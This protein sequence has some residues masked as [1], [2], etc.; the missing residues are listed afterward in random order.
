[1]HLLE[2]SFFNFRNLE[3]KKIILNKKINYFYGVNAQ[4]KTSVLEAVY[5]NLTGKSFRLGISNNKIIK[6]NEINLSTNCVY[7]DINGKKTLAVLVEKDKK[8]FFFNKKQ[9]K[10]DEF[11][12]KMNIISFT[13][14]DILIIN[15]VPS[16]RRSFFNYEISQADY[17]FYQDLKKYDKILK[18]RNKLIKENKIKSEIFSIYNEEYLKLAAKIMLN[19][20]N[21]IKNLSL[22]L[23]LNYRR[24]FN[25]KEELEIKYKTSIGDISNL[26]L[27]E[28]Y[29]TLKEKSEKMK[30]LELKRTY[31]CLGPQKDDFIF[32]LNKKEAKYFSSEG[33]K[34]SIIFSLKISEI[35]MILKEKKEYPIFLADDISSYF[36][37]IRKEKIINYL[38]KRNLQVFISSTEKLNLNNA[39]YFF[40]ENGSLICK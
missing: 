9:V 31:T 16:I 29:D 34:K 11:I 12:G 33:E 37:S 15:G 26:N 8:K 20:K 13:P 32:I 17:L 14:E 10:Y 39:S 40:M 28:I 21:Y 6:Y 23:N 36:D 4:G 7:E 3:N 30:F 35:D 25:S 24:L 38:E 27:E 1:M 22:M 2:I 18:I 5:F 19:R